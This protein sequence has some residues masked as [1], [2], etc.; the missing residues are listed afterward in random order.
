MCT[1]FNLQTTANVVDSNWKW[2]DLPGLHDFT[3]ELVHSAAWPKAFDHRNKRVAVIGNGSSG[4]QVVP[5]LQPGEFR[6][7][8]GMYPTYNTRRRGATVSL[9]Q[10]T[11]LDPAAPGRKGAQEEHCRHP[12]ERSDGRQ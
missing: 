3:G 12:E 11:Y 5:S 8:V 1:R 9:R 10:I 4:V 2:P 6:F 7:H